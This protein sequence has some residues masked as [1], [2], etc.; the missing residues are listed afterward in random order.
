MLKLHN[1]YS[2][3]QK[4]LGNILTLKKSCGILIIDV[5][6]YVGKINRDLVLRGEKL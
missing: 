6:Y 2:L 5:M 1:F 3:L 4:F